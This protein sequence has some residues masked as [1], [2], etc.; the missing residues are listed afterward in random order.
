MKKSII[1]MLS[2]SAL[3]GVIPAHAQPPGPYPVTLTGTATVQK[4]AGPVL[5]C[6]ISVTFTAAPPPIYVP[7]GSIVASVA[8]GPGTDPGCA[9]IQLQPGP[10]PVT[11]V[12]NTWETSFTVHNIY[13]DTTI[14]PGDCAGSITATLVAPGVWSINDTLN[15][16]DFGTGDCTIFGAV[17]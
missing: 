6:D 10:Y 1:A 9:T 4:N 8:I 3:L 7:P 16:V 14:T 17:S 11:Y 15:E 13:V 5:N 2:A 12:N